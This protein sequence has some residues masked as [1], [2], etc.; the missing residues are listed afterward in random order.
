[1]RISSKHKLVFISIPKTGSLSGWTFMETEFNAPTARDFHHIN[2]PSRALNYRKFSF[3]RNPYERFVSIYHAI[4]TLGGPREKYKKFYL[5]TAKNDNILTFAK[6]ILNKK[7]Y[8]SEKIEW[9]L[10]KSQS[11]YLNTLK[12]GDIKLIHIENASEE[13]NNWFKGDKIYTIPHLRKRKHLT[14]D[15]VKTEELITLV[16]NWA[17]EDFKMGNYEKE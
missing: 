6:Y 15:E 7:L 13:F 1:M 12:Y 14:W 3:I 11:E 16:N 4:V 8:S 2:L 10:V 17:G 5:K 9:K